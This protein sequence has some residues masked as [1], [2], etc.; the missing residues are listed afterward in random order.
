[1]PNCPSGHKGSEGGKRARHSS[2][3]GAC[4]LRPEQGERKQ[5]LAW[6]SQAGR[7]GC[8][9]STV[10]SAPAT[11]RAAATSSAGPSHQPQLRWFQ[12]DVA[13]DS[14]Q[15]WRAGSEGGLCLSSAL[16]CALPS[17]G[18]CQPFPGQDAD[19]EMRR[20]GLRGH[21]RPSAQGSWQRSTA[22]SQ[23]P[24]GR[25]WWCFSDTCSAVVPGYCVFPFLAFALRLPQKLAVPS[26][27]QEPALPC[28]A[29][30]GDGCTHGAG[31]SLP[32]QWDAQHGLC[33]S[34]GPEVTT[35]PHS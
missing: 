18:R 3:Y 8:Q 13:A 22:G 16:S 28:P 4:E 20:A 12:P 2:G 15:M 30:R 32:G 21:I 27:L 23:G 19:P 1:M 14:S 26:T 9:A 29:T 5:P 6:R 10:P 11:A 35:H 24:P 33:R 31:I 34:H 25:I 17:T 7:C